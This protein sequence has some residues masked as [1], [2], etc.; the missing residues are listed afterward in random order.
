MTTTKPSAGALTIPIFEGVRFGRLTVLKYSHT[1]SGRERFW[2]CLCDCGTQHTVRARCLR[3]GGTRSCGCLYRESRKARGGRKHSLPFGVA[4]ANNLLSVYRTQAAKRGIDWELTK[5]QFHSLIAQNC[6]YCGSKPFQIL[7]RQ[8]ATGNCVYTG[9]DRIDSALGYSRSNCRPCC[10]WCNN[11][12][13]ARSHS[14]FISW[15]HLIAN[16]IPLEKG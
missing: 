14:Q 5:E 11:A 1:G 16:R 10:K 2:L 9:I 13:A 6:F 3:M 8:Y 15:V 12:K 4:A 7:K